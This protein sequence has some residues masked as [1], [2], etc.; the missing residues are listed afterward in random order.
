MVCVCVAVL[1]ACVPAAGQ[2]TRPA[3]ETFGARPNPTGSPIG[4]G[5]GYARPVKRAD[6]RVKTAAELV[7]ALTK[8]TRGQVVYVVDGAEIDLTARVRDEKLVLRIPAG[9]TLAGGR[10]VD[11]STGA[12]LVSKEMKTHPLIST[13][14]EGVRIT[15][16]RL[17]GPDGE[18]RATDLSRRLKEGGHK[19]YYAVPTSDGVFCDHAG[20]EVDNCELSG[21]SHA[22]VFLRKG[23]RGAH[24]HHNHI[25]HCQRYGLGYGVCLDVATALIEANRFDYCRHH[26]AA[27]G[28]PGTGYE[29]RYNDVGPGANGHS[30]DM[31]GGRDRKDG[32]N[33]AGDWMKIHHNTFRATHVPAVVIRGL[34]TKLVEIHHNCFHHATA[35]AAV[36][37]LHAKGH[38]KAF[39]NRFG[40]EAG[41]AENC[42]MPVDEACRIIEGYPSRLAAMAG[43]EKVELLDLRTA[44]DAYVLASPRPQVWFMRDVVHANVRGKSVLGRILLRYFEPRRRPGGRTGGQGKPR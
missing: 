18:I 22:G 16:L 25:H 15:G 9:V 17:R 31:H 1:V 11:G 39:A 33:V 3:G 42:G 14:G 10:G 36:R 13:G 4:G 28:R 12:L 5:K 30:F 35:A 29:A 43:E 8:A 2:T 38:V 34:P 40:P 6:F 23:A 21:W 32:T 19:L 20:L 26:I 44:W 27:T 7:A 41:F 37:Q 24:I